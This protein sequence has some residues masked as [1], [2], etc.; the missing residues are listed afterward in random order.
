MKI[1]ILV[2]EIILYFNSRSRLS[3][4]LLNKGYFYKPLSIFKTKPLIKILIMMLYIL[5]ARF[6][7]CFI[8]FTEI[9]FYSAKRKIE[10]DIDSLKPYLSPMTEKEKQFQESLKKAKSDEK[11]LQL[12]SERL[13]QVQ[14]KNHAN[15]SESKESKV[16]QKSLRK[17]DNRLLPL[18]YTLDEVE[19]ISDNLNVSYTLATDGCVNMAFVGMDEKNDFKSCID[20]DNK[21]FNIIGSDEAK[22][23]TFIILTSCSE[24]LTD[25]LIEKIRIMRKNKSICSMETNVETYEFSSEDRKLERT[26]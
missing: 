5:S 3:R 17:F 1:L 16:N 21:I 4:M 10:N 8:V 18:A 19:Y 13:A 12:L 15:K 23:S 9:L 25:P 26:L 6:P 22:D 2:L 24:E 14:A 11:K 20:G 7:L